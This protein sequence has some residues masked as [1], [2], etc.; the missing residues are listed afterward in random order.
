MWCEGA[1]NDGIVGLVL[2]G[3]G[4]DKAE[5]L[6]L[7]SALADR[8]GACVLVPDLPGHGERKDELLTLSGATAVLR[9]SLD[10]LQSPSFIVGHSMGARLALLTAT[11]VVAA[12]SMPGE[13]VFDGPVREMLRVL[14]SR[15]VRESDRYGGLIDV[16]SAPVRPAES[17]LLLHAE[18][19]LPTVVRLAEEWKGGGVDVREVGGVDHLGIVGAEE[20]A[21][22]VGSW[23]A[24]VLT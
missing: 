23:L 20:T 18:H 15:R 7:A 24:G 11:P 19:D 4:G 6:P 1:E 14:R 17:T 12:L 8:L 21:D 9:E 13:P 2:H 10:T 5:M 16:L 22:L 3:Y